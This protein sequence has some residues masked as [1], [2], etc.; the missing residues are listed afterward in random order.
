MKT[1][2]G[3]LVLVGL[4][5]AVG[6]CSE[7]TL[8]AGFEYTGPI[9]EMKDGPAEAQKICYELYQKYD[10]QVYY[11][12]GGD[13][14]LR[15]ETGWAQTNMMNYYPEYGDTIEAGDEATST[16][17]LK[18]F[19]KFYDL[20]PEKLAK[21]SVR[22]NVLVKG[23]F[24]VDM[25]MYYGIMDFN[26]YRIGFTGEAQRGYIM[27]G[28]MNDEIGVQPE[29]WKYSL[30]YG[31]FEGISS[32]YVHPNL[33]NPDEFASMAKYY[34]DMSEEE[35][36][37]VNSHLFNEYYEL[38][39]DYMDYLITLGFVDPHGFMLATVKIYSYIDLVTFATWIVC[40][41]L[42]ER[43]EIME[44]NLL[45]K[46]KYELTLKYYKANMDLDLEAFAKALSD[47]V[48]E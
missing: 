26:F 48:I 11:T 46:Q 47:Y 38:N 34:G 15:L 41:P 22:R 40:K 43:Q 2:Y 44:N 17:F 32:T 35:L 33:P 21:S 14:A 4:I 8:E 1:I 10:L 28:D 3:F 23:N 6:A 13:E 25:L 18:F 9:P 12:L 45:V 7:D 16:A 42:D 30:S 24:D 36:K 39:E 37:E 29:A 31:F 19:K 5:V 20:L 27:W